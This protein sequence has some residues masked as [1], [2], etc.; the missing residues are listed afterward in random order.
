[1]KANL[2]SLL[3]LPCL[4]EGIRCANAS[5]FRNKNQ[6][7]SAMKTFLSQEEQVGSGGGNSFWEWI[8]GGAATKTMTEKT[9]KRLTSED[10]AMPSLFGPEE[11]EYDRYAACLAATEGLRRIRDKDLAQARAKG[12]TGDAEKHIKAQYVQN[13]SK[14]LRALGMSVS[15]FNELG[16][17]IAQDEQLKDK[18]RVLDIL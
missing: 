3:L 6:R 17:E 9:L 5:F 11:S 10:G 7:S 1:M 18:V 15:Q 16:R 13:S 14:V 12:R 4:L 8:R 2:S